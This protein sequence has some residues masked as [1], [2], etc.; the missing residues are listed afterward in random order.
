MSE[1]VKYHQSHLQSFLKCGKLYEFRYIRGLKIAPKAALTV[2]SSVDASVS[3][4][5]VAKIQGEALTLEEAQ[6]VAADTFDKLSP[7][8]VFDE[9]EKPGEMKD[10]SI[11]LSTLHH[12]VAAPL[13][14]PK[15]VQEEFVIEMDCGYDL[16][17]TIDLTDAH[18]FIRDTKTAARQ[19]ASGYSV[20]RSFQ[21]AMYSFAYRALRGEPE[22]GFVYDIL[23]KPTA[24]IA[25]EYVQVSGQVSDA[26]HNWLFDS[27]DQVHKAIQSG[28]ALPAPEGSWYCNSK[29]CGY[30]SICKGKK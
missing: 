6:A 16:G 9:D 28:V 2:G 24:K 13:I 3:K 21:P 12:T 11:K 1:R 15:T 25:P 10:M 30:W 26:D 18:G 4:N 29:W 23:K 19:N 7:E 14:Q 20:E 17:G 5:M 22:K 8:T 27:I